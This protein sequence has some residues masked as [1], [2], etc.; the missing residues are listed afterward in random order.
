MNRFTGVGRLARNAVLNGSEKK[1]L[2]FTLATNYGYNEKTEKERVA[3]V[4]C[5]VFQPAEDIAKTLTENGKGVLVAVDGRVVTSKFES[6]GEM[7]YSTE[8]AVDRKGIRVLSKASRPV[9]EIEDHVFT[10]EQQ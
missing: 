9:P 5:V 8:V 4:P 1:A 3:F 6:K 10:G 2:K 7:K